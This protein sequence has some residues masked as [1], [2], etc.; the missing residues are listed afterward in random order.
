MIQKWIKEQL[1]GNFPHLEWTMD[2]KTGEDH[3]A[4]VYM[5]TAGDPSNDDFRLLYPT[6]MIELESSNLVDLES[7]A[8][9]VY[10][11]M[12]RRHRERAEIDGRTFEILQIRAVP[13]LNLGIEDRKQ[14]F[15]VNIQAT[16]LKTN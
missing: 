12:D 9:K 16:L 10:E 14:S 5:E 1:Q 8:W 13:P 4:V 15:T 2:Y 11:E 3:T 6:Y 7:I